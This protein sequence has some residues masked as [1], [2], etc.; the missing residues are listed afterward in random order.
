MENGD[1]HKWFVHHMDVCRLVYNS[2]DI[3][4]QDPATNVQHVTSSKQQQ[5]MST[6]SKCEVA[7]CKDAKAAV[8]GGGS[9]QT[10]T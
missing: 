3:M 5:S 6:P 7:D 8:W 10:H 2:H 4:R 1:P 9:S